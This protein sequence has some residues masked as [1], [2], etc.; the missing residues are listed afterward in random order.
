[1]RKWKIGHTSSRTQKDPK[2]GPSVMA[3]STG[4]EPAAY[5]VGGVVE[6]RMAGVVGVFVLVI[7]K[8]EAGKKG[9]EKV[10]KNFSEVDFGRSRKK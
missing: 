5:R 1:M 9:F 10:F 7:D 3:R 8:F 4:F 6:S 2:R